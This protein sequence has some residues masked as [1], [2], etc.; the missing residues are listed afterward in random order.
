M[1]VVADEGKDVKLIVM[2]EKGRAQLGRFERDSILSTIADTNKVKITFAQVL[3]TACALA[4]WWWCMQRRPC[5]PSPHH[6]MLR[7]VLCAQAAY[8]AE[9][10][11]KTEYDAAFVI[12]NRFQ[13]AISF[14][15]TIST[16]LSPDV[17]SHC[18]TA[19]GLAAA[20]TGCIRVT[21][22]SLEPVSSSLSPLAGC[23]EAAGG[24][25]QPGQ[26]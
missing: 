3:P 4:S 25:W 9:E 1:R 6:G 26:V 20:C 13:T 14:K 23:G 24:R 2:G 10:V 15:P 12:F 7:H 5:R 11:L 16:V 19:L 18:N 17:G 21:L 22:V 8:L